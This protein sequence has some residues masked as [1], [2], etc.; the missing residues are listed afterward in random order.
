MERI[1]RKK[2]ENFTVI[3]NE[4]LKNE[5]VSLKAKGLHCVIMG[6]PN[7]WDFT[8]KG[9]AAILKDKTT[10]IYSAINELIEAG[11]C[12]RIYYT[13]EYEGKK[14][15]GGVEYIFY[16]NLNLENLDLD[17]LNLENQPQIRTKEKKELITNENTNS[18]PTPEILEEIIN[19]VDDDHFNEYFKIESSLINN[20]SK[21]KKKLR[22]KKE[23]LETFKRIDIG[24][25]NNDLVQLYIKYLFVRCDKGNAILNPD[26]MQANFNKLS[27]LNESQKME[28]LLMSIENNWIGLFPDKIQEKKPQKF[29]SMNVSNIPNYDFDNIPDPLKD[30][31]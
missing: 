19:F 16:E 29:G 12:K 10:A 21:K 24:N 1:T 3:S 8:I 11:Y 2:N 7:N 30:F 28:C 9:M 25:S 14:V 23:S 20:D 31:K 26:S 22:E 27:K 17:N 4:I 6:L 18:I 15:R 13:K 5:N